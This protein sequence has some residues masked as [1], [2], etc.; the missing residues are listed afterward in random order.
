MVDMCLQIILNKH[1]LYK[2]FFF[3][4][5]LNLDKMIDG[6]LILVKKHCIVWYHGLF[7]FILCVMLVVC[8]LVH[9]FYHADYI[10]P[11]VLSYHAE[12]ISKADYTNYITLK[13]T[14]LLTNCETIQTQ[15]PLNNQ[16]VSLI[17]LYLRGVIIMFV[18]WCDKI[19][20]N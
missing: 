10:T 4:Y 12:F 13:W 16:H 7:Y 6:W 14:N 2:H 11:R 8:K 1:L 3:N 9:V 19:H 18:N 17:K 15:C 20:V 5:R